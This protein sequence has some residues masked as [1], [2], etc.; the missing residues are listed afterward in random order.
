MSSTED[1]LVGLLAEALEWWGA[2][3]PYKSDYLIA[4]HH[5]QEHLE[6]IRG[7]LREIRARS[8]AVKAARS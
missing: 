1:E 8:L 5:D 7:R 4:R 3:I 6:R 2:C